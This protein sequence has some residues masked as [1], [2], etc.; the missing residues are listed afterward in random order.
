MLDEFSPKYVII[1]DKGQILNSSS[2]IE[3]YLRFGSGNFQNNLLKLVAD[4]LRIG[5]RAAITEAKRVR[6]RVQHADMSLREDDRIQPVMVT[7]QPMPRVGEDEPLLMVVFHD[8]G[9]PI[10]RNRETQSSSQLDDTAPNQLFPSHSANSVI[11]QLERELESTR[12]DLDNSL[13]EMEAAHE[14]MKSSNEELLSMNEELQSANEELETSKEEIRATND[15][16]T[17]ANN[18]LENLLRS[19]QVA[20]VFLDSQLNIRSF[21]PAIA[22]IYSLLPSDVGRPLKQFVP[23]VKAM[24]P[25]PAFE[26]FAAAFKQHSGDS[27]RLASFDTSPQHNIEAY[28]GKSY[29]RRTLPYQSHAGELEGIVVTFTDVSELTQSQRRFR[30]LVE[31]SAQIVWVAN[32][33][34][35]VEE[36]SPSWRTFTGQTYEQWIGHGWLDAVHEDDRESAKAKWQQAVHTGEMLTSQYR[37]RHRDGGYRWVQVRAVAERAVDGS[38]KSWVGMITDITQQ[39]A[40]EGELRER[41]TQ[42][43]RVIDNTIAFIGVV[44]VDGTVREANAPALQV[45]GLSREQVV[46][47]KFWDLYWWN[48]DTAAQQSLQDLIAQ[49]ASGEAIRVDLRYQGIGNQ[50]RP[51]DFMLNPV[52]DSQGNVEHLIA[53]GV[54]IYDRKQAEDELILAK[55]RLDLTLDVSDVAP[56]SWDTET[57]EIITSPMLNRL[58]G[59]ADEAEP[60]VA[61][62]LSRL[63]ESDRVRVADAIQRAINEGEEYDIDYQIQPP[64]GETRHVR[65][66]GKSQFADD[67]KFTDFIGVAIDITERKEYELDLAQREAHLRRVINNQLGL[68]GVVAPDGTLLEI[69]DRSLEIAQACRDEVVGRHFAD[70]PWWNYDPLVAQQTR[71]AMQRACAGEVVRYDVSLFAHGD[72]GVMIDFMIAPVKNEA[73]EVEYLIPSG[74]DIRE[75]HAAEVQSRKNEHLVRTI[76]ENSTQGLVMMDASGHVLY[77]NQA[78]LQMTGFDAQEIRSKPLHDLI[79]HH[80][81][82]G[83]PYPMSECPIDRALPEDFSVRAHEDLFFRK[84][85]SAFSVMCAASP[86]FEDGKPVSTVIEVRD[87]TEQHRQEVELNLAASRLENSMAFAGIAAWG[88]DRDKQQLVL[89]SQLKKMWGFDEHSE[90]TLS[91]FTSRID[92]AHRERV[93]KSITNALEK[94]TPYREEYP[95]TLPSGQQRWIRA[96]GQATPSATG[97]IEDFFGVTIDVTTD[98]RREAKA[99]FRA[100]LLEMLTELSEP[101][102]IMHLATQQIAAHF[103]ASRCYLARIRLDDQTTEV[104]YEF[105][106]DYFAPLVGTYR[107]RDF[108]SDQEIAAIIQG[109]PVR[110]DDIQ[111]SGRSQQQIQKFVSMGIRAVTQGSFEATKTLHR[112]I[113]ISKQHAYRWRDDEMRF[114]DDLTEMVYLRIERAESQ[115]ELERARA[116]AEAASAS[117]SAFVANMSHEIRTPMTAILGYT[118]LIRDH[119]TNSEALKYLQTVRRNG[120]YLLEVINDI[121]DLSKIEAGKLD[122]ESERFQPAHVI[123]DVRSIMEVRATEGGLDLVVEYKGKTPKFIQS[124]G[125]R[126]KQILIN[127]VGNAIKFT[128]A[129]RVVIRIRYQQADVADVSNNPVEIEQS[130]GLDADVPA[131]SRDRGMLCFDVIDTGIGMSEVQQRKLF[132]PFS[133]GDS[134]VSRHFGGTGLGLAIS[135]R[136]ANMLGGEVTVRST[137]GVGSTFTLSISVGDTKK[138]ELVQHAPDLLHRRSEREYLP[139]A[140]TGDRNEDSGGLALANCHVLIVDDRRDIR[141]LSKMLLTKAGATVDECEDGQ[142]A[143]DHMAPLIAERQHPAAGESKQLSPT[144]S[145]TFPDLILLDMQMPNLDGYETARVLRQL[146]YSGSIIALTADAMQGDMNDCIAAGCND[147]LSKPI[148]AKRLIQVIKRLSKNT[149]A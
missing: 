70:A 124:D 136:L 100:E 125:K 89:D 149:F 80:Y 11:A 57:M 69:D 43:R 119:I 128:Q 51:V 32:R 55:R 64:S 141:F 112:T 41:E 120:D 62:F 3:K 107:I 84:D 15:A 8:V 56:W 135:Q 110:I 113:F 54:D 145:P 10:A 14:E 40:W 117:K 26:D 35:E 39:K 126:L 5:L 33:E 138:I 9:L 83:R 144:A 13:Q 66:V 96:V 23:N 29:I 121:L 116:E 123:E 21:T 53:S 74:V 97:T 42:L 146:G 19:T 130:S 106:A 76:A 93:I 101:E 87:L 72:E 91:D 52:F 1:D 25:L 111:Q 95:I 131:G 73:G 37:L 78:F 82:D 115:N 71:E 67:G 47:K 94:F 22:D 129:G 44:A 60:K 140:D 127:L 75:R 148:D 20:T 50:I 46:G 48:F 143:V 98:Q 18:D 92:G 24:P 105:H 99:R 109:E 27:K 59:F 45:A 77:C 122:I 65:A 30:S 6:R 16:V 63:V 2:G 139:F 90:V 104:F 36:D 85:G 79:H 58:F 137:L 68:V 61:D 81:P 108:L 114:L 102:E 7:V 34:G 133:Q 147:Y 118:D 132:K 31:A 4:E 17:R 86:I 134:S 142:R 88:W 38:I 103:D 12:N 28:S 49:A